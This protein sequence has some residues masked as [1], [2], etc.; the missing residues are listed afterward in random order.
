MPRRRILGRLRYIK[1]RRNKDGSLR[2]YVEPPGGK[3]VRLPNLPED[4]PKFLRAYYQALDSAPAPAVIRNKAGTLAAVARS[5]TDS[6]TWQSY[7]PATR[8][9]RGAAIR[10]LIQKRGRSGK[11]TAGELM[12]ADLTA[13]H[14]RRD[15]ED[16]THGEADNRLRAWRSLLGHAVEMGLVDRSVAADVKQ[17]RRAHGASNHG[18]QAWSPEQIA[19]FRAHWSYGSEERLAFELT[20]WTS[21]RRADVARFGADDVGLDGWIS[22]IQQKTQGPVSVPL[23]I[24]PEG[25]GGLA[26]D[27]AHLVAALAHAEGRSPWIQTH[28]G[29]RRSVRSMSDFFRRAV[30]A[31]PGL[32]GRGLAFHGLRKARATML[33]ELGWETARVAAWTGHQTLKEV[34]HYSRSRSRRRLLIGTSTS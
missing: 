3:T 20:Y 18:F 27:H 10:R 26:E 6:R 1:Y 2:I 33:I 11:T 5:Y 13:A 4:H 14:L 30:D 15:I 25:W 17:P 19:A 34:D 16:M 24:L 32:A 28:D 22:F 23:R 29:N 9:S 7:S 31:V 21:A 12:V 8:Q